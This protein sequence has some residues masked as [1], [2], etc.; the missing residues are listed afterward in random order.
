MSRALKR[1]HAQLISR[2]TS[3]HELSRHELSR[4]SAVAPSVRPSVRVL[5]DMPGPPASV[6]EPESRFQLL[7]KWPEKVSQSG[8]WEMD[9]AGK[10]QPEL[11]QRTARLLVRTSVSRPAY[12]SP[13]HTLARPFAGIVHVHVCYLFKRRFHFTQLCTEGL[14][15]F[16]KSL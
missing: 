11:E 16:F 14:N 1:G 15:Y 6:G 10:Q 13:F 2:P 8:R 12:L 3:R 7:H 9:V 4:G 5:R